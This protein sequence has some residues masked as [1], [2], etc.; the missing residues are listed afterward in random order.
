MTALE[1]CIIKYFS[2]GKERSKLIDDIHSSAK[3]MNISNQVAGKYLGQYNVAD[4]C[5]L[6][7]RIQ[8]VKKL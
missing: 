3:Y 1:Y 8:F 5:K 4:G 7:D 2:H 6:M